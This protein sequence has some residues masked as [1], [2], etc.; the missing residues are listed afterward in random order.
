MSV[1]NNVQDEMVPTIGRISVDQKAQ[2]IVRFLRSMDLTLID[3]MQ[4][5]GQM[6]AVIIKD[7]EWE[8]PEHH[9]EEGDPA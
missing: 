1:I 6:H 4:V 9:Q 5:A 2:S 3:C 8:L 7:N